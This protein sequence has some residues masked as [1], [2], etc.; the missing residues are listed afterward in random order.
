MTSLPQNSSRP[1]SGSLR[2]VLILAT[3]GAAL[4]CSLVV[5]P[6]DDVERCGTA[7][8][9]EP[10]GDERYV[11]LCKFDDE[12]LDL[13]S[14]KIDKIC[15]ASYRSISC[16]PAD[17]TGTAMENGFKDAAEDNDCND[18]GC[19]DENRGKIGCAP[20]LDGDCDDG[21]EVNEL[22]DISFCDDPDADVP[23]IPG[24]FLST[25]DD[26]EARHVRDQFCKSF[27]CDDEFVCGPN[28]NCQPC[29]ADADYGEGGCG[30][31]YGDGAPARIYVL[32][33]ELED[34]CRG[35]DASTV[36]PA[37]FGACD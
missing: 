9:C 16:D 19:S 33:D 37:V 24:A 20:T 11:P 27:F 14:T 31:V 28:G 18:L 2:G 15:V 23:V 13:D 3:C 36:E 34:E 12:N 30:L 7:E 22:G 5:K 25:S 1:A 26:H 6:R 29:D 8:D 17:Y 4:A 21:L 35:E 10:T 32:G